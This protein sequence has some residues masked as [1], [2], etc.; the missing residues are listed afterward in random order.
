M[1][2]FATL[3]IEPV[4]RHIGWS[5]PPSATPGIKP[6]NRRSTSPFATLNV[7]TVNRHIG[8]SFATLDVE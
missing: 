2:S 7:E 6:V 3:D 8:W 1:P 4:N 5:T